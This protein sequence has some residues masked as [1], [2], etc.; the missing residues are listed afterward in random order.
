MLAWCL[1]DLLT[2]HA[3]ISEK[4]DRN[5]IISPMRR[6]IL[7]CLVH[8]QSNKQIAYELHLSSDTVKYHLRELQRHFNVRNRMQLV[9]L[10]TVADE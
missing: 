5:K 1:H 6:K 3:N 2:V 10:V 7:R 8:G 4:A 9:N